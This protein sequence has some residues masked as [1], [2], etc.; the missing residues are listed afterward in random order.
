[1]HRTWEPS[2]DH[3]GQ[4]LAW[5]A[6][7]VGTAVELLLWP[8]VAVLLTRLDGQLVEKRR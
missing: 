1:M 3:Y 6:E 5:W 4:P 7:A 2:L 8:V